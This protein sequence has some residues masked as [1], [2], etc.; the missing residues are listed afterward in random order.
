M[1]EV[2][3][4]D[5]RLPDRFWDKVQPEPNT[6]CWFWTAGCN[7]GGYGAITWNGKQID[8]HRLVYQETVG[9]I[10][11]GLEIDHLCRVRCCVNPAHLEAVTRRVNVLRGKG[12]SAVNAKVTHCKRG[13]ALSGDN[14]YVYPNGRKRACRECHRS[15]KRQRYRRAK[16]AR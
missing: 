13:H 1:Q 15:Y 6:G 5:A 10:G 7:G 9:P 3:F 16:E 2:K 8:S 14:V 12:P 11:A 4:G